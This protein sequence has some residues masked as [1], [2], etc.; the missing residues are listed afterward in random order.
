MG[1]T[2]KFSLFD[3]RLQTKASEVSLWGD[4]ADDITTFTSPRGIDQTGPNFQGVIKTTYERL[5]IYKISRVG[6]EI[7]NFF[8]KFQLGSLT[9]PVQVGVCWPSRQAMTDCW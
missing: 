6:Q 4:G 1:L 8:T 3:Y 2:F 5:Q 9:S 7:N